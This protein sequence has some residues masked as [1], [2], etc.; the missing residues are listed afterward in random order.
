[1]RQ[2]NDDSHVDQLLRQI[3]L[4]PD[5]RLS[6][7]FVSSLRLFPKKLRFARQTFKYISSASNI[8]PHQ[9]ADLIRACRYVSRLDSRWIDFCRNKILETNAYFYSR[10]QSCYLLARTALSGKELAAYEECFDE[11]MNEFVLTSLTVLLSQYRDDNNTRVIRK[12]V[13][14][15]NSRVAMV[16][17]HYRLLKWDIQHAQKFFNYVFERRMEMRLCDY[18]GVLWYPLYSNNPKI[19]T[20]LLSHIDRIGP[21]HPVLDLR[22][23]LASM[24]NIGHARLEKF[25]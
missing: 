8:Y 24:S 6:K 20:R 12:L 4:N 15:P 23:T 17:K 22:D 13:L 3:K 5:Y 1:M 9:E 25:E 19:L 18:I 2:I 21:R 16:G 7:A 14:H 10:I 11:E